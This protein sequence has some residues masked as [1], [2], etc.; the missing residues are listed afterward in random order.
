VLDTHAGPRSFYLD[1]MQEMYFPWILL[2]P[3]AVVF[4]AHDA[5]RGRRQILPVLLL[6][7]L[8]FGVYTL[9]RTKIPWYIV[10]IYP[11][12]AV[13]N[14]RLIT[15]AIRASDLAAL[16]ALTYAGCLAVLL[17]FKTRLLVAGFGFVPFLVLAWYRRWKMSA[18]A[19]AI[20]AF[21]LVAFATR[22]LLPVYTPASVPHA[23]V[24]AAAGQRDP[25]GPLLVFSWDIGPTVRFY[26]ERHVIIVTT[27][28]ELA[29]VVGVGS[30]EIIVREHEAS[31]LS[32]RFTFDPLLREGGVMYARVADRR[33]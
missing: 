33:R 11:G 23:G 15:T 4:A 21:T 9:M 14:A 6:T 27:A 3:F 12:L 31:W 29:Q 2:A 16:A 17:A 30:G 22:A 24:A 8:L 25:D 1:I 32:A 18:T 19:G 13:L 5:F 10:P 26:S 7:A 20:A 28:D